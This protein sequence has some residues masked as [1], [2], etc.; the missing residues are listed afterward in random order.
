M[1]GVV[2]DAAPLLDDPWRRTT[3]F[4][5]PRTH[6]SRAV[7]AGRETTNGSLTAASRKPPRVRKVPSHSEHCHAAGEI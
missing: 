1:G 2:C 3:H 7:L 5:R 4:S 6:S